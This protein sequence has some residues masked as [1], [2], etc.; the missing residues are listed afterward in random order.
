MIKN[1]EETAGPPAL[2]GIECGATHSVALFVQGDV[3]RRLEGG[4][5]NLKLL[6]NAQLVRH[7]RRL[8]SVHQGLTAPQA[9]AIGMA[10][11]RIAEDH[12]RIGR[13]AAKVWPDVPRRA[14]NDLETGLAAAEEPQGE[15]RKTESGKRKQD[16]TPSPIPRVLV[17]SG[18][19][20]C[21][22]GGVPG[23][24][25]VRV[26]GWGHLLG[27]Q[28]SGYEIGL[29]AMKTLASH[30]DRSGHWPVLGRRIL[31]ALQLNEPEDLIDWAQTA[32]KSEIAALAV[33][34]FEAASTGD[35][36]AAAILEQAARSLA[37]DAVSCAARLVKRGTTVQF[38]LAGSVLLKQPVFAKKVTQ[39]I[40]AQWPRAIVGPLQREGAWGAVELA[41]RMAG[42]A[43]V[44][45]PKSKV[46]AE[47]KAE[48]REPT[49]LE[50]LKQS[51]T[52]QRNP[53]SMKLDKLPLRDAIGLMLDED[54]KIPP[55]LLAERTQIERAVKLIVRS[56]QRGGCLFYVGA[57]TS[58]RLGVLDAS[59]CPPT[60]RTPPE[61]V[62]GIMAGGQTALWSSV[63]G[64]EDD[65]QAGAQAIAFRGVAGRDVVVGIAASGRTPFVWGALAEAKKRGAATVLLC[66]NPFLKIPAGQRPTVVIAPNVG[67]EVLTGSTRLKAGT[68]TKL[69]LNMLTTL[70][71]VKLGKVTS[72]LMVDL[73][74]SNVKLR[75][76]AVRIVRELTGADEAV[77]HA[78]LENTGWVVKA[79]LQALHFEP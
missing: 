20:S 55:A 30:S 37:G 40:K 35:S 75:N 72:N 7:F 5:A 17:L 10:G 64:A 56:F 66:F 14:S 32:G 11:A 22:F 38:V 49:G 33:Q 27:D 74:P 42:K 8:R 44:Q 47:S 21:C 39:L 57:G 79:A 46:G 15:K 65:A 60:F 6:T 34:V 70:A 76:R 28:G 50:S 13:A 2:L 48:G 63:E 26:G 1:T 16:D 52:E 51:P 45:S 61:M 53:R 12:D 41:A 36:L 25:T 4:P 77:A 43:K 19:G 62:Q 54:T 31:H 9:I 24:R 69:V 3:V 18:T 29:E 68:A 59:E 71:M 67:P 73:N 58:G 23:E 78:A